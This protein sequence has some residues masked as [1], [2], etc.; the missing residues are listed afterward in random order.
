MM[1]WNDEETTDLKIFYLNV[2]ENSY[3]RNK[4]KQLMPIKSKVM[5]RLERL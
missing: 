1:G 3:I 5:K 4:K 2:F